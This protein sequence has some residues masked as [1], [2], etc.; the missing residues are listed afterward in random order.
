MPLRTPTSGPKFP[1]K[2]SGIISIFFVEEKFNFS[3]E[4]MHKY[5]LFNFTLKETISIKLLSKIFFDLFSP[6]LLD[7][8]PVNIK[9]IYF[10][11]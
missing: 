9:P 6:I 3:F 11:F 10:T 8:P 1:V 7:N 2:K 4:F 5:H